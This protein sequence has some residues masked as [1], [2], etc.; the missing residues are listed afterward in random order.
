M[1][2]GSWDCQ[3]K[4]YDDFWMWAIFS[5]VYKEFLENVRKEVILDMDYQGL[6]EILG[7]LASFT[8]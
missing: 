3:L 6:I 2:L 7:S 1:R 8:G 4:I 5:V